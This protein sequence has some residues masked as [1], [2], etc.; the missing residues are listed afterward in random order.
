MR[1]ATHRE[2]LL[3]QAR[4]RVDTVQ[5]RLASPVDSNSVKTIRPDKTEPI[6]LR[7]QPPQVGTIMIRF[8]ALLAIAVALLALAWSR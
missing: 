2:P 6:P 5:Q 8:I 7:T 3:L 1:L 4:P